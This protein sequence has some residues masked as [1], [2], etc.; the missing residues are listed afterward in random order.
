MRPLSYNWQGL[1]SGAV[2][3]EVY[4]AGNAFGIVPGHYFPVP[5][6]GFFIFVDYP[7]SNFDTS[8][9]RSASFD[10]LG[11][12]HINCRL[13]IVKKEDVDLPQFTFRLQREEIPL[14]ASL[15]NG[16][17]LAYPPNITLPGVIMLL[18]SQSISTKLRVPGK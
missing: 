1:Q 8:Q 10:V 17:H 7:V 5:D 6:A 12:K 2:G 9:S 11:S 13:V 14:E 16:G 15:L 3:Q 4:G 18:F